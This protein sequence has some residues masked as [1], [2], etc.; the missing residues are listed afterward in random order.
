MMSY[1]GFAHAYIVFLFIVYIVVGLILMKFLFNRYRKYTIVIPALYVL[2]LVIS[3]TPYF[4]YIVELIFEAIKQYQVV[5]TWSDGYASHMS[6]LYTDPLVDV[7]KIIVHIGIRA[8]PS[9]IIIY[10]YI[11]KYNNRKF[12]ELK[13]MKIQDL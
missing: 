4:V 9:I 8:V 2:F 5:S 11:K 1:L 6:Y 3:V 12:E 7:L 13:K 10:N